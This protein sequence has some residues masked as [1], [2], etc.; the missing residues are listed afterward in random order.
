MPIRVLIADDHELV[1]AG[2]RT[3]LDRAPGIS[4][5]GEAGS[6]DEVV[7]RA[8]DCDPE[9]V[10]LDLRMPGGGLQAAERLR[11]AV[12]KAKIVALTAY[13]D[14]S[15]V[16]AAVRQEFDGYLLKDTVGEDLVRAIEAVASGRKV[17]SPAV[18]DDLFADVQELFRSGRAAHPLT[19]RQRDILQRI[20]Q[21]ES[22]TKIAQDLFVSEPTV[23]REL[24]LSIKHLHARD[25]AEAVAK[26]VR[27]GLI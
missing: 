9:V 24:Y 23:K 14:R 20:A 27:Q 5:V 19:G 21:G 10:L 25:R 17:A 26:A 12:P 1:R 16:M 8:G 6:A 3:V 13:D 22:T 7:R 18:T 2:I 4:V 15:L 11:A